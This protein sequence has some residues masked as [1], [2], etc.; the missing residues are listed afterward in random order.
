MKSIF[1]IKFRM[2]APESLQYLWP[3]WYR[4][5]IMEKQSIRLFKAR[6]LTTIPVARRTNKF[7]CVMPSPRVPLVFIPITSCGKGMEDI[8]RSTTFTVKHQPKQVDTLVPSEAL[9]GIGSSYVSCVSKVSCLVPSIHIW[10]SSP[11]ISGWANKQQ[12]R[13]SGGVMSPATCK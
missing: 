1:L 8:S 13:V 9:M 4:E 10:S 12:R 6:I 7:T 11:N 5:N 3:R 2:G